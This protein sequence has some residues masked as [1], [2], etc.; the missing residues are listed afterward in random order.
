MPSRVLVG[1]SVLTMIIKYHLLGIIREELF[2][3]SARVFVI[4]LGIIET[5]KAIVI[6]NN[7]LESGFNAE[8]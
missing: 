4:S 7:K 2:E 6:G 8:F 5:R 3:V 1:K